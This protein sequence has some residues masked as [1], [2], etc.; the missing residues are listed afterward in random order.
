MAEEIAKSKAE[1]EMKSSTTNKIATL[2]SK[3]FGLKKSK[4]K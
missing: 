4:S 2:P 1:V 3:I